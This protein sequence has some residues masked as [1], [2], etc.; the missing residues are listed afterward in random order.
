MKYNSTLLGDLCT[1]YWNQCNWNAFHVIKGNSWRG[2]YCEY[3]VRKHSSFP[4][5]ILVKELLLLILSEAVFADPT[6]NQFISQWLKEIGSKFCS[7]STCWNIKGSKYKWKC[8][9]C[10]FKSKVCFTDKMDLMKYLVSEKSYV[11]V[12]FLED[13]SENISKTL[14]SQTILRNAVILDTSCAYYRDI[15]REVMS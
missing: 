6:Q 5:M 12:N 1:R 2:L 10:N 8:F 4:K 9:L 14:I 15:I 13:F 7:F 3:M 11:R